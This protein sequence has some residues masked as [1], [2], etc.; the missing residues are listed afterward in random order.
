MAEIENEHLSAGQAGSQGRQ[1]QRRLAAI[2]FTDMVGYSALSQ[3][4]ERLALELLEEHRRILRPI[5]LKYSGK[6]IDTA[7]DSFFVEFHSAVEAANCAIEIQTALLRRN[8]SVEEKRQ[9]RIRIGLHIGD[10]VQIGTNLHGDGVNIAARLEPLATPEGICLSEDFA[11]AVQNKLEYP[12]VKKGEVILKN[13]SSPM[14]IYCIQLPWVAEKKLQQVHDRISRKKILIYAVPPTLIILAIIFILSIL[15]IIPPLSDDKEM[16][17]RIAVL[18]FINIGGDADDEYFADGMTEQIISSLSNLSGLNVIA[19]SSIMKYKDAVRD[20]EQIGSELNVGTILEGSIRKSMDKTRITIRLIDVSKQQ[21]IWA[22]DYD[23]ELSDVFMVQSEIA[24]SIAGE[25]ELKLKLEEME[26]LEKRQPVNTDAF[27]SYLLG[28][29][30]LNRRNIDGITRSINYFNSSV[31]YDSTFAPAYTGLADAYTLIA[32]GGYG[33]IPVEESISKAKLN[34]MKALELDENLA[35][36]H[37]SLAYIKFRL[38]WKFDEAEIEFKKAIELGPS[39]AQAHEWYAL[40]LALRGRFKEGLER[41]EKAQELNPLSTSVSNGIG[42]IYYFLNDTQNAINQFNKTIKMDPNYAE[43]HFSLAMA[44]EFSNDFEKA[45]KSYEKAAELS[46]RRLII[47]GE[48]AYSYIMNG[49]KDKADEIKNELDARSKSENVSAF[50][51]I[52]YYAALKD[53]DKAFELL[54]KAYEERQGLMLYLKVGL[55]FDDFRKDSRYVL[56]I[57]KI[58]L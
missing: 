25:L 5:F 9:V 21:N 10:V 33:T 11:R 28:R 41:M 46:N 52:P 2:M 47:I 56:M 3:S 7:G 45:I 57:K 38:E 16:H 31:G 39:Y 22:M 19:R 37:A 23:K 13:I 8:V 55:M 17:T 58:G 51:Y 15:H 20:I 30:Y 29:F 43:A 18:P 42:R 49:R 36:A 44:Y 40:C 34:V 14:I 54:E 27:N 24:Q 35:E 50:Y 53:F 1:Q 4:D 12:V 48:M 32:A 6:E 26:R